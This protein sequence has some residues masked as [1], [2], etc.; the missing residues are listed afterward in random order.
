MLSNHQITSTVTSFLGPMS[1][2]YPVFIELL[3]RPC[4]VVG[5]GSV[6]ERKV[7]VLLESGADVTV[8]SPELTEHLQKLVDERKLRHV[9]RTYCGGALQGAFLVVAA[10]GEEEVNRAVSHEARQRNML[11]NVVDVPELCN[12][13]VPAVCQRGDLQIAVS[14]SGRAPALARAIRRRLEKLIPPAIAE[15]IRSLAAR[16]RKNRQNRALSLQ[17]RCELA[18]TEAETLADEYFT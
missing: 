10:T 5:G 2:L 15:D 18:R 12:F 17:Q 14:T 7:I 6:A 3:H 1:V 13:F 11:V 16:R 8:V 4:V 9:A